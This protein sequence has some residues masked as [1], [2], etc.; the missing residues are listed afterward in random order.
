M[1]FMDRIF[2]RKWNFKIISMPKDSLLLY[3][4]K[5]VT[6]YLQTSV[7]GL[8]GIICTCSYAQVQKKNGEI[9]K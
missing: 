4:Y 1:P 9:M 6:V 8:E 2:Q 5:R 3:L 7:A